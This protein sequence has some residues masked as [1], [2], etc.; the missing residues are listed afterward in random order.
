M[1]QTAP[2]TR[3]IVFLNKR[4]FATRLGEAR[5]RRNTTSTRTNNNHAWAPVVLLFSHLVAEVEMA[6]L[7]PG[8][9]AW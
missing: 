9:T 6:I 5:G 3:E 7:G 2:P 1:Y 4:D 8:T